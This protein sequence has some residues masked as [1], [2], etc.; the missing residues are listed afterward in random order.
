TGAR[1]NGGASNMSDPG[2]Q[3]AP[4][5]SSMSNPAGNPMLQG[6]QAAGQGSSLDRNYAT[7]NQVAEMTGGRA[8]FSTNDL[9]DA[10]THATEDGGN[11]YTLT[12]APPAGADNGKCHN[13]RVSLAQ[14]NYQLSYRR[15]YCHT[16]LISAPADDAGA[17]SISSTPL[18]FPLQAGDVLQGNMRPGAPMIHDLIFSAHLRADGNAALASPLQM[19]EIEVQADR[20][21]KHHANK[22]AKP[23]APVKV[24]KYAVDYRVLDPQ[25]KAEA[26]RSGRPAALEFAVAAFDRDGKT[27]NGTV[28]DAMPESSTEQAPENKPGLYRV[29]QELAVPV[30]AV[31][32]RVGVRDRLSDRMGTLEVP[33]PLKPE[34][35]AKAAAPQH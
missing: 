33:L 11:Y 30:S 27:L 1:P 23:T 13:I 12:Y 22:P 16:P 35:V 21:R 17:T 2:A 20:Y 4:D 28:N 7:E 25:L 6:M 3:N 8:F 14:P 24:Q 9:S 5:P 26:V 15:N 10:L 19:I 34:A 32:I 29:H 31:S 18:V